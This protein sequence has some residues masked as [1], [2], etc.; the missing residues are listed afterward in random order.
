MAEP[1]YYEGQSAT[2]VLNITSQDIDTFAAL[3][4]DA[5]PLHMNAG[6]ARRRGFARRVAHGTLLCGYVSGIFGMQL[7][8]DRCL[9]H[10]IKATFSA[11]AYEGDEIRITVIIAQ[12]SLALGALI[13]NFTIE[14]VTTGQ[15]LVK[16]QAQL[17]LT[18]V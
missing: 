7:P 3:T 14:R 9:M 12:V 4:G 2:T 18:Q 6:F 5:N 1:E 8:G 16:G 13:A 11:P 17:G 10:S 15:Q